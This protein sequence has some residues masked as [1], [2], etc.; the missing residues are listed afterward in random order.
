MIG[1]GNYILSTISLNV[2]VNYRCM[3]IMGF[4]QFVTKNTTLWVESGQSGTE[5]DFRVPIKSEREYFQP[6]PGNILPGKLH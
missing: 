5:W 6:S 1:S 4:V 2:M 3:V